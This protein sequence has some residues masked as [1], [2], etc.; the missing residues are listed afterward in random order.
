MLPWR[1]K[2]AP[3]LI[4][5][6]DTA[7]NMVPLCSVHQAPSCEPNLTFLAQFPAEFAYLSILFKLEVLYTAGSAEHAVQSISR[8]NN[9]LKKA[10]SRRIQTS[11]VRIGSC[12]GAWCTECNGSTF[13]TVSQ[14]LMKWDQFFIRQNNTWQTLCN[15]FFSWCCAHQLEN[16]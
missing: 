14:L 7:T 1:K 10:K 12:D 9:M 5:I 16:K 2:N 6:W 4:N 3:Y 8:I 15:L 11:N 13:V